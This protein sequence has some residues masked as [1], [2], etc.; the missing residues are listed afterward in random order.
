MRSVAGLFLMAVSLHAQPQ[1]TIQNPS[2]EEGEIG[3]VPIGW[4]VPR[5]LANAGFTAA[6]TDQNCRN[7]RHQ[8][9]R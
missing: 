1:T 5:M 3:A 7:G 9:E 4:N 8:R 6:L 2:F